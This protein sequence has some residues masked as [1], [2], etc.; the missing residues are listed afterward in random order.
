MAK[1]LSTLILACLC[2][3]AMWSTHLVGGTISYEYIGNDQYEITLKIYRDCGPDNT[4]GTEF[5]A[6]AFLGIYAQGNLVLNPGMSNLSITTL[7]NDPGIPCLSI[8]STVCIEEGVYSTIE[9]LPPIEGG[10]DIVYQ[11][12]CRTPAIINLFIPQDTGNTYLAHVPGSDELDGDNSSPHFDTLPPSFICMDILLSLDHSANE[13]DGDS[14]VYGLCNPFHGASPDIPN[15]SLPD[16]PPY[17][18]VIWETGYNWDDPIT[19]N[20]PFAINSETGLLTGTPTAPGKYALGICVTEYRNDTLISTIIRDLVFN[21]GTCQPDILALYSS[22]SEPCVG[23]EIDFFNNSFNSTDY[24]WDFGVPG[25]LSDTSTAPNPTFVFPETGFYDVTLIAMPGTPCTDSL[26]LTVPVFYPITANFDAPPLVCGNGGMTGTFLGGGDFSN[27]ATYQWT[28]GGMTNPESSD[29]LSPGIVTYFESGTFDCSFYVEDGACWA[30]HIDQIII[31]PFPIS[32]IEP[33]TIFCEGTTISFENN[34]LNSQNYLWDF[35]Q[36]ST[37]DTSTEMNPIFTYS[38]F[39]TYVV[40]LIVEPG[41]ACA[42]TSQVTVEILSPNPINLS[43]NYLPNSPCDS[44]N[45]LFVEFT[46]SGVSDI[47]WELGDG[48]S[49]TEQGVLHYYNEEGYY[50]ITLTAFQQLCNLQESETFEV[51]FQTQAIAAPI[52][53]PNV[54]SPNNDGV[55]ESFRP[56]FKG[57][58]EL[59]LLPADREVF[60]YLTESHM[61]IYDRWGVLIYDSV[62]QSATWDGTKDGQDM[63]EGTYYY[64]VEI[65]P[66]CSEQKQVL[67]GHFSVLRK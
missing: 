54:F 1:L 67:T 21:I 7:P 34:S 32:E 44:V 28:F 9:T 11:R 39:G 61:L 31:D 3:I 14:L 26:T 2:S 17:V 24:D 20:T 40:T 37:G 13:S 56:F 23:L 35:G 50:E 4:N 41:Q 52:I 53:M 59:D 63:L 55:N 22:P 46:G 48:T 42:D 5:D 33:Q 8:P 64:I 62:D 29:V 30:E 60:D 12:C 66:T 38:D 47:L 10:Y 49:S 57:E 27:N 6:T 16:P 25:T 18:N 19:S 51:Y 65:L 45:A 58:K 43:Y 36:G 15:P